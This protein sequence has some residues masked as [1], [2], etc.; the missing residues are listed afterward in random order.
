MQNIATTIK[1]TIDHHKQQSPGLI[2]RIEFVYD[3]P[4]LHVLDVIDSR[5]STTNIDTTK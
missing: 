4:L 1:E 3:H 5:Y 2:E